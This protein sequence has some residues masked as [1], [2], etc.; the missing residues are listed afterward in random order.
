LLLAE[1]KALLAIQLLAVK[2]GEEPLALEGQ[3]LALK[4]AG[5]L[6]DIQRVQRSLKRLEKTHPAWVGLGWSRAAE[7]AAKRAGAG[8]ALEQLEAAV[9]LDLTSRLL[10]ER[11]DGTAG[12]VVVNDRL[13]VAL[14]A[15]ADGVHLGRRSLDIGTARRLLG[16]RG[17]VGASL[18][19]GDDPA[20]ASAHGA[21]YAFVGTIFE[22]PTHPGERP[23]GLSGMGGFLARARDLPLVGIGGVAVEGAR[24]LRALGAH[25]VAAIRGIW[26]HPDP[27]RA[28]SEYLDAMT[29]GHERQGGTR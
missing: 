16:D 3:L 20:T 18:H 15:G 12:W 24:E 4:L 29:V 23:L 22:T 21:R 26:D 11:G 6:G 10:R 27:A 13:D 25:G 19:A 8:A 14:A 17:V 2:A 28:A 9:A 1:G 7:G 5:L